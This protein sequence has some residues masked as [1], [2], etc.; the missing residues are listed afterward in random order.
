MAVAVEDRIQADLTVKVVPGD[1]SAEG[2]ER[3]WGLD[4]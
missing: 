4:Q 3:I 1:I 2:F